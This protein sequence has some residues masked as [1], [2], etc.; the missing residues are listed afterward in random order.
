[1]DIIAAIVAV[2]I[3]I[4]QLIIGIGLAMGSIYIGIRLLNR[5]TEGIDEEEELKKGNKAVAA[6]LLG[7]VIAIALV[8]SSGVVGLTSA[9]T[10]GKSTDLMGYITA[11]SI[12]IVQLAAG[13]IFAVIAIYLAFRVWDK[14]TTKIDETEELKKGNLA[15]GI[16]MAGIMIAVAIV[17]QAGVSGLAKVF[18]V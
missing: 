15:I 6:L 8:V 16:V 18:G 1:M 12:G 7:V 10:G 13:I 9:I 2:V 17:I 5:L 4:A 11:V 14:I 3:W